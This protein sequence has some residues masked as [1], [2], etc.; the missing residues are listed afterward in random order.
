VIQ[1]PD[2]RDEILQ[3]LAAREIYCG[4]HYP[5][6]LHLQQAYAY[7]GYRNGDFPVAES[8][9]QRILSLPMFPEITDQQIDQVSETLITVM[10]A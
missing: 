10:H 5:I 1:V 8:A 6:P 4:I 2:R 7:L 9:A 3:E